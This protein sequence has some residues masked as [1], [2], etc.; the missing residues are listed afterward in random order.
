MMGTKL[1]TAEALERAS[2]DAMYVAKRRADGR[3]EVVTLQG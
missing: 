2:D 1:A 3:P